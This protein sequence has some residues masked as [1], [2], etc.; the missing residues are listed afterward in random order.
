MLKLGID[1]GGTFTDFFLQDDEGIK[2]VKVLSTPQDPSRAI[3]EGLARLF[4]ELPDG[5]EINHGSTVATNAFLERKGARTVL[6]TTWG[7]EDVLFIGRQNRPRLYDLSVQRS[8]EIIPPS[9]VIGVKERVLYNGTVQKSL[10]KTVGKRLRRLCRS[11]QTESVV[12]CLL[13]SYANDRHE[14]QI[15]KE[16]AQLNIP[17]TLSSEILPEFREYERLSTTLINGYLAPVV[18]S[19]IERLGAH[20]G[21]APLFI[22]QSNGGILPAQDIGRRAVYTLLSGP[23]GGVHGAGQLAR[24][25][26]IPRII[27]FDMGGTSTDVALC[28]PAPVLT[29]DYRIDDYPVRIQVMDIHTVGAGG[30]SLA[31]IDGGGLLR[32]GPESAGADP[33]PACYGRGERLTVTD[34]NLFLGRLLPDYFLGGAMQLHAANVDGHISTLARQLDMSAQDTALG[35]IRI[36]NASMAKAIRAVTL[37]RG[38]D[39]KDF[40]LFAF[41]GASGLHCC[42][43]ANDLGIDRIVVP[44]RAGILSAQG[45]VFSDYTLDRLQSL[46]LAGEELTIPRLN[47]AF[48]KLEQ[49]TRH[50]FAAICRGREMDSLGEIIVCRY[51]NLRYQGQSHELCV[52]FQDNFAERFH[53]LHAYT[54]G[55]RMDDIGLELI[56]I[57][58]VVK[59]IRPKGSLPRGPSAESTVVR[60]ADTR[61]VQLADGIRD[62]GVFRRHGLQAGHVLTGPALVAD[63][64]ATVLLTEGFELRVDSLL[65]LIIEPQKINQLP[66]RDSR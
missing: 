5:L 15:K 21:T 42:E 47:Q 7:F 41:G 29:R 54:Y 18:A 66:E 45:M 56:S 64:Y 19:Y 28:D 22:Q 4:T 35:I 31:W 17:I 9:R 32:V 46:F 43:L 39:P 12:V 3:I 36:V 57:Q 38:H 50:E 53:E 16:L 37:E 2:T 33:G 1:A 55:H 11:M 23:A 24:E 63:D 58:C 27:T 48:G 30:G 14:Q 52:E 10:G 60:T 26:N 6:I 40:T 8:A 13:H 59:L 20:V 61:R 65:N 34:A 44:A 51:L 62:V 49:K 25:M